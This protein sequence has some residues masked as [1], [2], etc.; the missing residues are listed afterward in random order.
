MGVF[1][2]IFGSNEP[3]SIERKCKAHYSTE[4]FKVLMDT[5]MKTD[6]NSYF[7][8]T[9][10]H[11][12]ELYKKAYEEGYKAGHRQCLTSAVNAWAKDD[13]NGKDIKFGDF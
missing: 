2:E 5:H 11:D 6:K 3:E 4:M 7:D 10:P 1:E 12:I 8:Q 13:K 9:D